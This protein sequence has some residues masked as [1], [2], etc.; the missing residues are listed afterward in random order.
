MYSTSRTE[1]SSLPARSAMAVAR[2]TAPFALRLL[3]DV[4]L[5]GPRRQQQVTSGL[6]G[7]VDQG[8]GQL[9]GLVEH[10]HG[11]VGDLIH[12]VCGRLRELGAERIILQ[13]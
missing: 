3:H 7:F 1:A 12:R 9:L 8:I 10:A 11:L 13:G 5:L 6:H 4:A 2:L